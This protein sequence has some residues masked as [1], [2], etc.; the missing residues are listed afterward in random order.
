MYGQA[1]GLVAF[2]E[3]GDS[4]MTFPKPGGAGQSP[5]L[6]DLDG[7]G[8]TEVAAGTAPADSNVYTYDAG[9]GTWSAGLAH[10]PTPRGDLGRTA[11]HAAGAP[12][13]LIVDRIRPARVTDLLATAFDATSTNVTFTMTG[14][15][16]LS[17][18]PVR[19]ELRRAPVRID[20]QNFGT[21][22]LA[23]TVSAMP[24][25]AIRVHDSPLPTNSTWWY[26][27]RVFD[28]EGNFSAVSNSDSA[29]LA[30]PAVAGITDLKTIAVTESTATLAW[31][32][33]GNLGSAPIGYSVSGSTA[34]LD[35]SNVDG[36][37]LQLRLVGSNPLGQAETT[38]V[39]PLTPG[40]RWRFTVRPLFPGSQ[41]TIS[42]IAEAVTPVGGAL[43]GHAGMAVAARP[44]PSATTVTLDWQ[45]DASG[46]VQQ[47]LVVYDVNGRERRRIA[48]GTEPGGSYN[49]DGRDGES[50]LLPAGLYFVRLVSGARHAG[51][52]VVFVR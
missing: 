19:A 41:A 43:K 37:P 31:T 33:V 5:S 34:P 4:L 17:G 28:K 12:P 7:D 23:D 36:A 50:R 3:H 38:L 39:A 14:D 40:R 20:D 32:V 25:T 48:L 6:A 46:T 30:G 29:S 10:W 21:A 51:S 1:G 15:D 11:S 18:G 16:S 24:G 52:R 9:D 27:V 22:A 13:A 2:D 35:S 26:A 8:A 44:Q 47:Y 45:G 42:N 49:W